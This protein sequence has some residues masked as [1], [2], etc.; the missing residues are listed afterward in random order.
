MSEL[1]T[2]P[3]QAGVS[4][5]RKTPP[6]ERLTKQ[7]EQVPIGFRPPFDRFSRDVPIQMETSVPLFLM[8]P[9]QEIASLRIEGARRSVDL[10][11]SALAG[12]PI[13][14]ALLVT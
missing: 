4:L 1:A 11:K 6:F 8:K 2:H 14:Y 13:D 12:E 7:V 10:L 3:S 9:L 5:H